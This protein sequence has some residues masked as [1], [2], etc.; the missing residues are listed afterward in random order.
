VTGSQPNG[1]TKIV[2]IL[3]RKGL[4]SYPTYRVD[5]AFSSAIAD[6]EIGVLQLPLDGWMRFKVKFQGD[7]TFSQSL[8]P[9]QIRPVIVSPHPAP[10][11][12]SRTTISLNSL[13]AK[14]QDS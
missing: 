1:S 9:A 8:D 7:L 4:S 3:A 10:T 2:S 6:S 11:P 13:S 14:Y 12:Q 5:E